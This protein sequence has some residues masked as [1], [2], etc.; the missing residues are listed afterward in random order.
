MFEIRSQFPS[1]LALHLHVLHIISLLFM[2]FVISRRSSTHDVA[3]VRPALSLSPHMLM[4]SLM[5]ALH[6]DSD[7]KYKVFCRNRKWVSACVHG[8][9]S[10]DR[11]GSPD[12]M[13]SWA[14]PSPLLR[15]ASLLCFGFSIHCKLF[16]V[17]N[18]QTVIT[19]VCL[20]LGNCVKLT[21]T[22]ELKADYVATHTW[23]INSCAQKCLLVN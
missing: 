15:S 23:L 16:R 3:R 10:N 20:S 9:L 21:T 13:R 19:M 18:F 7:D 2:G 17:F 5:Q 12:V 1:W 22:T 14:Q 11:T 8:R 6:L 4:V